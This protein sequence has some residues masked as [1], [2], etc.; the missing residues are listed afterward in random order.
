M[1]AWSGP[2]AAERQ[3]A[4]R[5]LLARPLLTRTHR[6]YELA[7]VRRHDTALRTWCE[8]QLGW[9]LHVDRDHAR[10]YK[11]PAPGPR[12]PADAP[13]GRQAALYCVTL[14][15]LDD[16][17]EQ[18]V[19]TELAQRITVSTTAEPAVRTFDATQYRDRADLV[20]AIRLLC[21]QRVL[22]PEERA[23]N[24]S[25]ERDYIAGTGNALYRVH[26]ATARLLL[27][28]PTAPSQAPGPDALLDADIPH[29]PDAAQDHL[30]HRLLRRLVDDPVLYLDD[31]T[32][33]EH[34]Y[35]MQHHRDLITTV[36]DA[37]DTRVETRAEGA[38]VIDDTLTD[39]PFP[40]GST[41]PYA[42]LAL[43]DA[44]WHEEAAHPRRRVIPRTRALELSQTIADH[45]LHAV[46]NINNRPVTAATVLDEAQHYLA[47]LRLID[48]LP[49]GIRLLPALA[50]YRSTTAPARLDAEQGLLYGI[51][52][53][54]A[55]K[56]PRDH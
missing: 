44:L 11:I 50:R 42:A 45:L 38:A 40:H 32:A 28:S 47:R 35:Y 53:S 55:D 1:T 21:H 31:L 22:T 12:H 7:L 15:A 34:T 30:R 23:E 6:P 46:K 5:A 18:T 49:T 51:A 26:H 17:D 39:L 8:T 56:D 43:A 24:A 41:R 19:I 33:D 4:L 9:R 52:P 3:E 20:A 54:T 37:L 16:C 29:T 10:L 25:Y 2:D 27:A 13:T 36:E 14:A 48:V